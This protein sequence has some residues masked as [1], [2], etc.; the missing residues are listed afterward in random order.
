[1]VS[2]LGNISQRLINLTERSLVALHSSWMQ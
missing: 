1:M 2:L